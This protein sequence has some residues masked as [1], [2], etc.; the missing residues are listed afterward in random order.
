MR[1]HLPNGAIDFGYLLPVRTRRSNLPE[2]L[3]VHL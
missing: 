2:C 1:K 3:G